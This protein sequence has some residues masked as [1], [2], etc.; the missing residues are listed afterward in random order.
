MADPTLDAAPADSALPA[1]P[2]TPGF[3][4]GHFKLVRELGRGGMGVVFE[5]HDPDLDR[6]VAIKVVHERMASSATAARLLREA[7]AMAKLSHPSVVA[8]YE[9]GTVGDQIFVVMELVTGETLAA[10]IARSHTWRDVV[11]VLVRAGEGLEAAHEAGL[12]HRDFKPTNAFVDAD[13]RARVGDFGLA[14]VSES[15]FPGGSD[16]VVGTPGYMAPEQLIGRRVDERADQYAFAVSLREGLR[17][18][19]RVP[20]RVRS[21]IARALSEDR[22]ARFPSMH[23]LLAEL[24]HALATRRRWIVTLVASA[25]VS[26]GAVG[27]AMVATAPPAD[28]CGVALVDRVWHGRASVSPTFAADPM[29]SAALQVVDDWASAWRLGRAEACKADAPDARAAR[30]ACLDRDLAELHALVSLWWAN[31]RD[32]IRGSLVAA[33]S[34]PDPMSCSSRTH[35]PLVWVP[36]DAQIAGVRALSHSG[37]SRRARE[38]SRGVVGEA[39]ALGDPDTLANALLAAA[40]VARDTGEL[41]TARAQL[42]RAAEQASRASDD[43]ALVEALLNGATVAGDQ[44]RPLDGLGLADAARAI[45]ARTGRHLERIE[46]VHGEALRD[47]GRLPEAIRELSEVV[48]SVESRHDAASRVELAAAMGGLASAYNDQQE[49]ALAIELHRRVA[50][51]EES[52]LGPDHP[53][54][55]KTLHD[56]A[57]AE[58]HSGA[59]A[60]AA[61]HYAR[62]RAI[63]VAADG[64][65]SE[66]VVGTDVSI[67]SL[68]L[69]QGHDDEAERDYDRALAE[70]A[71]RPPDDQLRATVEMALGSIARDRDKCADAVPHFESAHR[72]YEQVGDQGPGHANA[73]VDLGG[74]YFEAGRYADA[75]AML[76]RADAM[77]ARAGVPDLARVEMWWRQSE[78]ALRAGRRDQ[79]AVLA[80]RVLATAHDADGPD[81]KELRDETRGV[82]AKATR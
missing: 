42:S 62:A 21:A 16:R 26:A 36:L 35:V 22:D 69:Q 2:F 78:L 25:V 73:L 50:T 29:T 49:Y 74:C 54:L 37:L 44:G 68:A 38:L 14:D 20:R 70:M 60:D 76:D 6:R 11:A 79:S 4:I 40:G 34:L 19:G 81:Y 23:E 46:L 32:V 48:H 82:L 77:F 52:E 12:V 18:S 10:W 72:A 80:R 59:Y 65:A 61:T 71:T 53:E 7:Q 17:H 30:V 57:N 47:A 64:S 75:E 43:D 13:G 66:L 56:L 67:A 41:D 9:V 8:V 31:D 27:A 45:A 55:G 33:S 5:A 39:E 15:A 63:F 28:P 3:T 1:A 58:K 24:R 51:I